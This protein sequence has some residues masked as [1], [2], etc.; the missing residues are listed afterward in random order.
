VHAAARIGALAGGGEILVSRETLA[1][2]GSFRLSEPRTE[3]LRGF[4]HPVELVA[5][6]WR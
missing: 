1:G 5:V 3:T 4:E 2:I 6:D